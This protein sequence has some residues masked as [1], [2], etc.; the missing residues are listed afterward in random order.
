[1]DK[2]LRIVFGDDTAKHLEV[3]QRY[4]LDVDGM[5]ISKNEVFRRAVL[6]LANE[7]TKGEEKAKEVVS[8]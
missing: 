3:I 7:I 1:M 6:I 2:Q 8:E 4:F 5:W